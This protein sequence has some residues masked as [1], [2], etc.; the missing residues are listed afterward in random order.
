MKNKLLIILAVILN[1][2]LAISQ[3]ISPVTVTT[4]LTPP[5]SALLP[6]YS[7]IGSNKLMASIIFNDLSEPSWDTRLRITIE[8]NQIRIS[9]KPNFRPNT[10]ITL[11]SGAPTNISGEDLE[12]YLN[13]NNIDVAGISMSDLQQNG[14]LPEGY[15]T[16]CIEVYDYRS[17]RLLSN[18]GCAGAFIQL[19]GVPLVQTPAKGAVLMA[20]DPINIQFQWQ[21]STPQFYGD[22]SNTEYQLSIYKILDPNVEPQNSI[23]NN[24]VEQIFQ[25]DWSPNTTGIY[26]IGE[27][28]L[29]IGQRYSYTVQA[30]DVQG[31]DVFKNN[32]FSEVGWFNYGYPEGGHIAL[33]SPENERSF[34]IAEFKR[35]QWQAADNTLQNQQVSYNLKIVE[36]NDNQD[37]TQ[38]MANNNAWYEF[39]TQ[40]QINSPGG[41][42]MLDQD[43]EEQKAYAWQVTA[44]TGNQQ[45]A[46][47]P[48]YQFI[49]PPLIEWFWAGNHKVYVTRTY[50]DD[51]NNLS[52]KGKVKINPDGD[53]FEFEFDSLQIVNSG[54]ENTLMNGALFSELSNFDDIEIT[55]N[56]EDNGNAYFHATALRLNKDE[57]AIKG[58]VTWAFPHAVNSTEPPQIISKPSWINYDN[59]KLNG[60]ANLAINNNFD[61]IDPANFR[62]ELDT[63]SDFFIINNKYTER[64]YGDILLPE[65]IK[66]LSNN[67]VSLHFNFVDNLYYFTN[68][69]I[70]KS[71]NINLVSNT[72]LML[73]PKNITVDLSETQSP[74]RFS[75]NL[76]WKGIYLNDFN[77]IYQTAIDASGQMIIDQNI[78][79]NFVLDNSNETNAWI[80]HEGLNLKIE[81]DF[82][83]NSMCKFNTFESPLTQS[84]IIIEQSEL[85]DGYLKGT[86][87][88]PFLRDEEPMPYTLPLS[89]DGFTHGY[90]DDNFQNF[91]VDLNPDKD[92]LHIAIKVKQAVFAENERLDLTVDM[93]WAAIQCMAEN[94]DGLS[95]W[96]D[97]NI[98]FGERNGKKALE[99]QLTGLLDGEY[100]IAIDTLVASKM[101]GDYLIGYIGNIALG[102]DVSSNDGPVRFVTGATKTVTASLPSTAVEPTPL[103]KDFISDAKDYVENVQ[104]NVTIPAFVLK[105]PSFMAW[106]TLTMV[107]NDPD[108]GDAFYA[109][110]GAK[111]KKPT[112]FNANAS[113]LMGKKNGVSYWLAELSVS[114]KNS[115]KIDKKLPKKQQLIKKLDKK[116]MAGIPLGPYLRLVGVSGRFYHHMKNKVAVGIDCN[117][118]FSEIDEPGSGYNIDLSQL[119]SIDLPDISCESILGLLNND[120]MKD[121]LDNMTKEEF[122]AVLETMD[123]QDIQDIKQYILNHDPTASDAVNAMMIVYDMQNGNDF[124]Y[125]RIARLFPEI[126]WNEKLA[127]DNYNNF[128][129]SSLCN[130]D[131][132][133]PTIPSLCDMSEYVL[134][135]VLGELPPPDYNTLA[136]LDPDIDWGVVEADYPEANWPSLR[137][138]FPDGGLCNLVMQ[139][140]NI[141]WGH[142]YLKVPE[143]PALPWPIDWKKYL[144]DI[145]DFDFSA[146]F[147]DIEL[148]DEINIGDGEINVGYEINKNVSYGAY[149]GIDIVDNPSSGIILD[150]SGS[151]EMT[152]NNSGGLD[153]IGLQIEPTFINIPGGLLD[154]FATGLGCLSYIPA[155]NQFV[156]DFFAEA[157]SPLMCAHGNLHIDISKD[158]FH[159]NLASKEEP[160]IVQQ[161]CK[162][163]PIRYEGFFD[164]NP[165]S[166]AAGFGFRFEEDL[167]V[168]FEPC[169]GCELG[170]S[171]SM[172]YYAN[173]YA[174]INYNPDFYLD[175]AEFNAGF[176]ASLKVNSSG[177]VCGDHNFTVA[178]VSLEGTLRY[179]HDPQN[180]YGNIHGRAEFLDIVEADVDFTIDA[181]L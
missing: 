101:Y 78:S 178:S 176:H 50:N 25:S 163:G 65:N 31:R 97:Q 153:Q 61:L 152:F 40:P 28:P 43:I 145:P 113:Y 92:K 23:A 161:F 52:G 57:L 68:E 51:L 79:Q 19:N 155:D 74:Q 62:I 36:L 99:T 49:G 146:N 6:D 60:K 5:Y 121:V 87:K 58:T 88:V 110:L 158:D 142:I 154:P 147:P 70:S 16:F 167:N 164:F 144:P 119:P 24:V 80:T 104:V 11:F 150:A 9:T 42:V 100:S 47:S 20:Q 127:Q 12:P 157:K 67:R 13:Y 149:L 85:Q 128:D 109:E 55:P 59:L 86:I 96:G 45:I 71:N 34:T 175:E 32:G 83:Q 18:T 171:A 135:K 138:Y 169:D 134:N 89:V 177:V 130:I 64:F 136:D 112:V 106:G 180:I 76:D 17:N 94:I 137:E 38:A 35:F 117:M 33:T 29:E 118:D 133:W 114:P 66:D 72:K 174:K 148:P 159:I 173:I 162:Y 14:K 90:L 2:N 108:W 107:Y 26:G 129:W 93:D 44:H 166:I 37:S 73:E 8:S 170:V 102:D 124:N 165:N 115:G 15:Y 105:T 120:Q 181:D 21:L 48:I 4:T 123:I 131:L 160:V 63:I 54:G 139:Y 82:A 91:I 84:K 30:R 75:G 156:G 39:T 98:G 69:N 81:H 132:H 140:P 103:I 27:P 116:R 122:Y 7:S 3:V 126:D 22:P 77:V 53:M 179:K 151:L 95:I 143:L 111:V 46:K 10:P 41:D 172:G 56:Y 168:S 141:D 125:A 1:I